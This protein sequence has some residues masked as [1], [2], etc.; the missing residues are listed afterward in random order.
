M[1]RLPEK[2]ALGLVVLSVILASLACTI[3]YSSDQSR[4]SPTPQEVFGPTPPRALTVILQRL[5]VAYLGPDGHKL[6][7]SGCP[8]SDGLGA[9]VDDHLVVSGVDTDRAVRRV[10]VAGDNGTLTWEW[11]CTGSW[12]LMAKEASPGEW[13][14]F[15]APSYNAG[16]YTV[17]FFYDDNTMAIGMVGVPPGF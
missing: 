6:I 17:I 5:D 15:I 9:I 8:G 3:D 12:A 4:E 11:P 7:G 13:D 14:V 2:T 16:I 1:H 10:L